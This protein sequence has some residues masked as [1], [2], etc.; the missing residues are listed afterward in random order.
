MSLPVAAGSF[1]LLPLTKSVWLFFTSILV[2]RCIA[3]W[4]TIIVSLYTIMFMDLG[5]GFMRLLKR[6][7]RETARD[8]AYRVIKE[9][10]IRLELE[11]GC[12]I[13]ENELAVELG[14]SRTPVREALLALSRAKV[15][16]ITPQ[17]RSTVAP[18][19]E[20]LVEEAR[21]VRKVLECGVVALCC[22]LITEADLLR[23]E[24]NV[25]LQETYMES[26]PLE[27]I[28]DLDNQFHKYLFTIV[29][30]LEAYEMVQNLAVHFDRIRTIA[31]NDIKDLEIVDDHR[32]ILEAMRNRDERQAMEV[33]QT[34]LSRATVDIVSIREKYPHYFK[35]T[36]E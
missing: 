3:L 1:F 19:D 2:D 30:K 6:L 32:Q 5:G 22:R 27:S 29:Q 17:K 26:G 20:S 35:P 31:L 12:L 15:V 7:P 25:K 16:E 33:M 8:Y 18:I 23:L 28:H 4:Y 10:I 9:N 14:L 13:S 11:P 34:H 24:E 21:F 36:K